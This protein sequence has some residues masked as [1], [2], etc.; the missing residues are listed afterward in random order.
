MAAR[1]KKLKEQCDQSVLAGVKGIFAHP[2]FVNEN[3]IEF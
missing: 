2:H 1:G 3:R